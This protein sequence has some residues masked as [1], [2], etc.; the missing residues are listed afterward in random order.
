LT[1]RLPPSAL[2]P[3][4]TLFRPA[5]AFPGTAP[6]A[7]VDP[8]PILVWTPDGEP[9]A[10]ATIADVEVGGGLPPRAGER[11]MIGVEIAG[12]R[13]EDSVD[14]KSTRLNS[15]HVKSSYAV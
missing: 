2:D 14:R 8:P 11:S 7:G 9:P 15:S 1:P 10:N 13:A 6:A 5:S 3:Y 12:R 4:T